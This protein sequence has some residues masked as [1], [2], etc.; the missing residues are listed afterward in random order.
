MAAER[1]EW[2]WEPHIVVRGTPNE[3]IAYK[4]MFGDVCNAT[5]RGS[6]TVGGRLFIN[7][8]ER[9][10]DDPNVVAEPGSLPIEVLKQIIE[11]GKKDRDKKLLRSVYESKYLND[12]DEFAKQCYEWGISEDIVTNILADLALAIT[13]W[14]K[15]ATTWL[16]DTALVDNELHATQEVR[17][18]A[19]N[20]GIIDNSVQ[21]WNKLRQLAHRK[22]LDGVERG[23]WQRNP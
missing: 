7:A 10:I 14:S 19:I 20:D 6:T 23:F 11:T 22:G 12:P 16:C 8:L 3:I 2:I 4:A 18:L 15:I 5:H 13:P 17:T 9:A 21:E 1:N